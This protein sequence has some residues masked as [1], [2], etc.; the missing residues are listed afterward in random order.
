MTDS[1]SSPDPSRAWPTRRFSIATAIAALALVGGFGGWAGFA[2]LAGAVIAPGEVRVAS[3]RQVVQ[4]RFGGTVA[5]ILA[6]DGDSVRAGDVLLRL[7]DTR[8]KAER[9]ILQRRLDRSRARGTRLVAER[10]GVE[11]ISF[12]ADLLARAGHDTDLADLMSGEARLFDA[13]TGT[14]M[15]ERAQLGSRIVQIE[16]E[17]AGFENQIAAANRQKAIVREE[18]RIQRGLHEQGLAGRTPLVERQLEAADIDRDLASFASRIAGAR[19]RIGEHRISLGRLDAERLEEIV[20]ELRELDAQILD[21][22][23]ELLKVDDELSGIDVTAPVDGIVHASTDHTP[24]AVIRPADPVLAIVPLA[25]RLVVEARVAP[26]SIDEI[27]YEQVAVVR[28][29][30]FNARTTPEL[31]GVVERVSP[32]RMLDEVTGE[33]YYAVEVAVPTHELDR[34][35]GHP[36]IPGMPAE[37]FVRTSERTPLSYL[38]KPLSDHLRRALREE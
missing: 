22:E 37:V 9:A 24:G 30:A 6:R 17:I 3:N 8:L 19:S 4:H 18:V 11:G 28:F 26:A 33:P 12:S 38:V 1:G 15:E 7:N 20:T 16:H 13:R 25:D 31:A 2:E 27:H 10:D 35:D 36:L 21:L 5:E 23:D 34:L 32:D 14:H 29:P